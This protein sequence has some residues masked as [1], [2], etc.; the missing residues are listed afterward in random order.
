MCYDR[1]QW[2]D[3]NVWASAGFHLLTEK[4][5]SDILEMELLQLARIVPASW[6]ML[7][8]ACMFVITTFN[9]RNLE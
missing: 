7:C 1:A 5:T 2:I 9:N 8:A 4:E 3:K 6:R